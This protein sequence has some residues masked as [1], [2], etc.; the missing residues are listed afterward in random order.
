MTILDLEARFLHANEAMCDLVR[1]GRERLEGAS[2]Y[3]FIPFIDQRPGNDP[4]SYALAGN[5]DEFETE[6]RAA[7]ADGTSIRVLVQGSL[8]RST[9]GTPGCLLLQ[10]QDISAAFEGSSSGQWFTADRVS[11]AIIDSAGRWVAVNDALSRKTGYRLPELGDADP[12]ELMIPDNGDKSLAA[13]TALA[14]E[15]EDAAMDARLRHKKGHSVPV[16]IKLSALRDPHDQRALFIVRC[17]DL[18]PLSTTRQLAYLALHDPL[19]GL[20]N[21]TLLVDRLRH[22]LARLERAA[23]TVAV[24]VIDLDQLKASNDHHG[25]ATGDRLLVAAAGE[26]RSAVRSTDTVAR[27][28]GDEFVVISR[29]ADDR[30]ARQLRDRIASRLASSTLNDHLPITLQASVGVATTEYAD[31][32]IDDLLD[33][34][35]RHMYTHEV[36]QRT[37][38]A[39]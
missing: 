33:R 26:I 20:A 4:I 19:T 27:I 23:G 35:D 21:R 13:L 32:D 39:P 8:I 11:M 7:R 37:P 1:A 9:E 30:D 6:E 10:V 12:A 36:H 18:E 2:V 5:D 29:T 17:D 34:A 3:T 24:L 31:T 22:E 15:G 28:G 25:H 38:P 14:E 16:L